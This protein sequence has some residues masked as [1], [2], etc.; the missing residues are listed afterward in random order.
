MNQG[1]GRHRRGRARTEAPAGDGVQRAALCGLVAGLL[2]LAG[3][4]SGGYFAADVALIGTVA[5]VALAVVALVAPR[6]ALP[7]GA[8]LLTLTGLVSFAL[9][10]GLS[11]AWSPDPSGAAHAMLRALTYAA[12]FLLALSAAGTGRH[13]ALLLRLIVGVLV[14][15][16]AAALLSRLRPFLVPSDPALVAFAGGRL[17]YPISYWNGLG[18]I[19]AMAVVATAALGCDPRARRLERAAAAAGGTVASVTLYLT[20]SRASVAAAAIALAVLAILSPR[21]VRLLVS[22]AVIGVAGAISVLVVRARPTL[23]D[24]TGTLEAQSRD[25]GEVLIVVALVV[26]AAAAAQFLIAAVERAPRSSRSHRLTAA[27]GQRV[28]VAG[29]A[30]V[31]V[32]GL[33]GAAGYAAAGDRIEGRVANGVFGAE[34]FVDRQYGEFLDTSSGPAR[35]QERLADARSS[36]SE[37]FRVARA[38]F[39]DAPLLGIGAAGFQVAWYRDREIDENIRNAHSLALE[40]LAELGVVGAAALLALLVGMLAGLGAMR[41]RTRGL[42]RAQA[43]AASGIVVVWVVHSAL[44]WDWQLA[45]VTLPA[46]VAAAVLHSSLPGSRGA[47][48]TRSLGRR[49]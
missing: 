1:G 20:L 34:S 36:R 46:L 18:A 21:R 5:L 35:G 29:V 22:A 14:A 37:S 2:I 9:L 26:A 25:G 31:A 15:I 7:S 48:V 42:T 40:T 17:S 45:A 11:G 10:S 32:L 49:A 38:T 28:P 43:A 6:L 27:R 19:A 24:A 23:V 30:A 41:E 3:W 39:A 13:A 16:C 4:T 8:G 44:D 47:P 12:V 33:V